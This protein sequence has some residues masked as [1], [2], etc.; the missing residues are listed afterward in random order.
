MLS[1]CLVGCGAIVANNHLPALRS[2]RDLWRIGWIVDPDE[3]LRRRIARRESCGH[4]ASIDDIPEGIDACLVAVPNHLHAP[5]S[6]E[7]LDRGFAVLCEKP[8]ADRLDA[9]AAVL[10]R[11]SG[12]GQFALV[13]QMRFDPAVEL[14]AALLREGQ[15]GKVRTVDISFGNPFGWLSRTGFYGSED[16]AGGGGMTDLGCHLLDLC[17]LLF[18]CPTIE[19]AAAIFEPGSRRM[20]LAATI[21]ISLPGGARGTIRTS[22]IAGLSKGIAVACENGAAVAAIGAGE[23]RVSGAVNRTLRAANRDGFGSLWRGFAERDDRLADATAG[24]T[25]M[26]L[27]EEFYAVAERLEEVDA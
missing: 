13:H 19:R 24:R 11:V 6:A 20:D 22:R 25:V 15:L 27:I 9:C 18:G 16:L 14:L 12:G 21:E 23:V 8:M 4:S 2:L 26:E 17:V 5:L 3:A 7:L 10:D 1:V